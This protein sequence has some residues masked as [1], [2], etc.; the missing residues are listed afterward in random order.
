[1]KKK[2]WLFAGDYYYP[3]GGMDDL[4]GDFDSL[5]EAID[6]GNERQGDH[7]KYDWG[8]VLN[9]EDGSIEFVN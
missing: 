7:R 5:Q 2:F 6:A 1:M 4:K 9:I 3:Q 8:H